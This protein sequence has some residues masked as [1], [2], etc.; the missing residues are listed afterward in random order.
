MSQKKIIVGY[1]GSPD[2]VVAATWALDHALLSGAPVEFLY[3]FEEPFWMPAASMVPAPAV[4]PVEELEKAMTARLDEAVSMAELT[5]PTV[6]TQ[7]TTV[8]AF[9]GLTLID[10][11]AQAEL[12][13]VGCRGHSAVAGLLGSVS[14]AVTAHAHC[15][16]VIVRGDAAVN[17]T[18]VAGV[19]GSPASPDVLAFAAE[20]AAL[21]KAPLRAIRAWAPVTGLWE[22]SPLVTR[23]VTDEERKPFDELVAELR[24]AHP[25]VEISADAVVEHP[26][27]ALASAS[28]TAQ[29]LVVGSRGRGPVRGLLLGSVSQHLL[30]HSACT[31]AVVPDVAA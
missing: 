16:V 10:R 19:D 27:A 20:Q 11:S 22:N 7:A 25:E 29:L 14:V 15:P 6:I 1:D 12:V 30:R 18:V 4:R 31:V 28:T 21:R 8:R 13:V 26:A 9:A 2:A 17:A 5:H 3:A 24:A 23:S